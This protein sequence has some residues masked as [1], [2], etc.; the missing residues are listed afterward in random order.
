MST[1]VLMPEAFHRLGGACTYKM[2]KQACELHCRM[3]EKT[4]MILRFAIGEVP[5]EHAAAIQ[6]EEKEHGSF[7]RIP[8]EQVPVAH[9]LLCHC[10]TKRMLSNWWC[11]N[12]GSKCLVALQR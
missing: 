2:E 6:Q 10:S 9:G 5:A 8:I 12:Q 7:L 1:F 3:Y 11:M 4:G